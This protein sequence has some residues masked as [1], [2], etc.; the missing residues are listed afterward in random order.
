MIAF[1]VI[2]KLLVAA[3]SHESDIDD[4]LSDLQQYIQPDANPTQV[5][6]VLSNLKERSYAK[7]HGDA[8]RAEFNDYFPSVAKLHEVEAIV[9]QLLEAGTE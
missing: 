7:Y 8:L 4:L 5:A 1:T 6:S 2:H 9:D 3:V